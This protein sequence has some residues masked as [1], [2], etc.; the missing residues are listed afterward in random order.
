M[1][2]DLLAGELFPELSQ[3][4]RLRGSGIRGEGVYQYQELVL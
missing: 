2:F 1:F 4:T 3:L